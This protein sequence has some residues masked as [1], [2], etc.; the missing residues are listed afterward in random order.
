LPLREKRS[1]NC[2]RCESHHGLK[3]R[4]QVTAKFHLS[5][6][7]VKNAEGDQKTENP[8]KKIRQ[9]G[10][11]D[12]DKKPFHR[13]PTTIS[14]SQKTPTKKQDQSTWGTVTKR[15]RKRREYRTGKIKKTLVQRTSRIWAIK[16]FLEPRNSIMKKK[17]EGQER[18]LTEHCSNVSRHR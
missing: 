3:T 2:W 18:E 9:Q 8:D 5:Q 14:T 17:G 15:T 12:R 11:K 13:Y 1:G 7:H 6:I 10:G 4:F 16:G